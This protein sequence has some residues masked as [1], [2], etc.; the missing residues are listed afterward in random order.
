MRSQIMVHIGRIRCNSQL[1]LRSIV[2]PKPPYSE[3]QFP[4]CRIVSSLC[5]I[6]HSDQGHKEISCLLVDHDCDFIRG[7]V[8]GD[9]PYRNGHVCMSNS[10]V[11]AYLGMP[12]L[13]YT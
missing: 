11:W 3:V 10:K 6:I 7:R 2:G 9:D 8:L 4:G 13:I 12:R 1:F 5:S